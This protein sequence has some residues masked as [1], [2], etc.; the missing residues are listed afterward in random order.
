M[1]T[2]GVVGIWAAAATRHPE[3]I[4]PSPSETLRALVDLAARGTLWAELARTLGRALSGVLVALVVGLGWSGLA[5]WSR[6]VSAVSRPITAALMAFPPVIVVAIALVW[7]GPGPSVTRLVIVA[8]ALPLVVVAVEEAVTNLD[9]DLLEMARAF[10][11]SRWRTVRHVVA[12]GIASPVTAVVSVTVGQAIRIAVMAELLAA[13]DGIG[14][15]IALARSNLATAA[16]FA[17]ALVMVATVAVVELAVLQ[18]LNRR[19]SRWRVSP[20]GAAEPHQ[21]V[22]SGSTRSTNSSILARPS[23]GHPHTR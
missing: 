16:L 11:L 13:S 17:W 3:V 1:A 14:A 23:A 10:G 2:L 6:W 7:F 22:T 15:E 18:P 9:P 21:V 5:G 19:L 4:L 12:P 20:G 8:V